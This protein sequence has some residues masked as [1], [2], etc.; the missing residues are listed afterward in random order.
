MQTNVQKPKVVVLGAGSL[1]FGRQSI[2]QM[3]HSEHLNKGTLALVDTDEARLN[4]LVKLARMVAEEN[5]VQLAVEGSTDR[6]DVL[7]DADFVVLSF[8]RDTVK[9]RGIDCEVSEKYGIRMCSGDTI[10][11]G[12]IFRAMRELP[13]IMDCARDIEAICPDAWVINYI[14]PS[15]VNGIA[16]QKFAPKLKS[17]ALCDGL[18]MPHVKRNYA[19]NAEI[20]P[21]KEAYTEEIANRFDFRIAGVNHFTWL[22]KA[23]FDGRDVAPNIA[24]RLRRRAETATNGGDTGAKAAYNDAIGYELYQAFGYIPTCV[25]HTKEYVRFWQGLGRTK[26]AIPQLSIW[27]TEERY[28][29]HASMWEQ[30][31]SFLSGAKPIS[32]YMRTFGPDHATDIIESMVGGLGKKFFVNTANRG[33]VPNMSGDAFLELMCEV[34]TDGIKPLPVGNMPTGLRGM[35]QIVLDT[36]ELTAEAV[37]ERS[38]AKLRR[39]MLTDPLTNSIA[40]AD[41]IIA[42]I[43][44]RERD[45]LP[46]YWFE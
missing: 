19:V 18:H 46:A 32:D 3:V 14:N 35:Q 33:A 1:F 43:M 12:G 25:A 16:L 8:A 5:G 6:R 40:D 2:W 23:E 37:V 22:L 9:Y 20:V 38:F 42:E 36:H 41:R 27:E 44:E 28:K 24:E 13:I 10:G 7:K 15:A 45:A 30:V 34:T 39:A 26:E 11:P 29:R 17:F 21:S 31:D 4:K